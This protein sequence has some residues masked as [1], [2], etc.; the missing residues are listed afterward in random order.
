MSHSHEPSAPTALVPLVDGF[1]ETEAIATVDVLR[2]CGVWVTTAGVGS[3]RV[4]GSHDITIEADAVLAD[5]IDENYD[6]IVLPGGPGTPRLDDVAGLHERLRRQADA[7]LW[8]CAICAAPTVLAAAGLLGGRMA[9]C[10]PG[11]EGGM[12]DATL[13]RRVVVVDHPF[14]TSR[15]VGTA[16][17]FALAVASKLVGEDRAIDVARSILHPPRD[18]A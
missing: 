14:I 18:E 11:A 9:T 5:V 10:F 16:I 7:G 12:Q 1:E 6:A 2:R 13:H 3:T 4:T 17:D 15:A 8:V